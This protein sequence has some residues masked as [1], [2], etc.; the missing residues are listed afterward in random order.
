MNAHL[1]RRD[2]VAGIGGGGLLSGIAVAVKSLRPDVRV[3]GVQAA[4]DQRQ[5]HHGP[6]YDLAAVPPHQFP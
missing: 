1:S 3:V 4:L 2:F 5:R 6:G